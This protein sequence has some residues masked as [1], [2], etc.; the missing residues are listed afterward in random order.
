MLRSSTHGPLV[1]MCELMMYDVMYYLLLITGPLIGFAVSIVI[2]Y[3]ER[4][5]SLDDDCLVFSAE[6]EQGGRLRSLIMLFEV[7]LGIDIPLGCLHTSSMPIS[8]PLF[9][10]LYLIFSLLLAVNMLIGP[11]NAVM[12]LPY[13]PCLTLP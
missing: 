8:G 4:G 1:L 6:H 12:I 7:M 9:M 10:D 5:E 13:C 3:D 11:H 2:L